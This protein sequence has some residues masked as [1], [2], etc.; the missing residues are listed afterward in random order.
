MDSLLL[1]RYLE[2]GMGGVQ[3][4]GLSEGS[5]DH[6]ELAGREPHPLALR[7][8][9]QPIGG[10]HHARL[11]D[12]FY[13]LAHPVDELAAWRSASL[14]AFVGPEHAEDSHCPVSYWFCSRHPRPRPGH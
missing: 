10:Q 2:Q 14:R 7:A 12:L 11:R 3:L 13:E 4:L 6:G 8:W 9:L 5:V 1:R